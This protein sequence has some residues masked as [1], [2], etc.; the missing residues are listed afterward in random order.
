M[1]LLLPF[2]SFLLFPSYDFSPLRG[3][4]F[5]ARGKTHRMPDVKK[6]QEKEKAGLL[7]FSKRSIV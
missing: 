5:S 2:A 6:K 7:F 4:L 1:N 3:R